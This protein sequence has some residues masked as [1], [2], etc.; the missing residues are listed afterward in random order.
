MTTL[1]LGV[2]EGWNYLGYWHN[3]PLVFACVDTYFVKAHGVDKNISFVA[4]GHFQMESLRLPHEDSKNSISFKARSQTF[5][6][7]FLTF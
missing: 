7:S 5:H 4:N 3:C 1:T 6:V 2:W